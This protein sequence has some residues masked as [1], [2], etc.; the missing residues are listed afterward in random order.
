L[1]RPKTERLRFILGQL[2]R[3]TRSTSGSPVIE[4]LQALPLLDILRARI[5]DVA[6]ALLPNFQMITHPFLFMGL[7][8]LPALANAGG[9]ADRSAL[10]NALPPQ[11]LA[12]IMATG[13]EVV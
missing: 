1:V 12:R 3:E 4:F 5:A 6:S 10:D 13:P 7:I 2:K 11:D 9:S 8:T